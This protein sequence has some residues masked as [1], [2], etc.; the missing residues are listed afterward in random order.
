MSTNSNTFVVMPVE[1]LES[2]TLFAATPA[3][4]F[5]AMLSAVQEVS[6]GGLRAVEQDAS[7]DARIAE[8]RGAGGRG[9]KRQDAPR[10]R[11]GRHRRPPRRPRALAADRQKLA[12]DRAQV[13]TDT[14]AARAAVA[15]PAASAARR[16]GPTPPRSARPTRTCGAGCGR[17]RPRN[18]AAVQRLLATWQDLAADSGVTS[19]RPRRVRRR[20]PRRRRRRHAAERGDRRPTPC[21][22]RR[23]GPRRH[24]LARGDRRHHRRLPPGLLQREHPRRPGHRPHRGHAVDPRQNAAHRR[25]Q[26]AIVVADLQAVYAAFAEPA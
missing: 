7:C 4:N 14:R 11:Q 18:A 22:R 16:A 3:P 19:A 5:T 2:R 13:R 10:R 17:R 24:D 20:P 9:G 21:E 23:R 8:P 6:A 15:G 1:S 25:A 26:F 12:A